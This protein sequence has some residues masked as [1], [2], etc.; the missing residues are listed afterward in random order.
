MKIAIITLLVLGG[1]IV[2]IFGMALCK[3]ATTKPLPPYDK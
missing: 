2:T 3:D 1:I